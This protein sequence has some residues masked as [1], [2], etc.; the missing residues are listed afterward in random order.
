MKAF[1]PYIH[2]VT[3][4]ITRILKRKE[5]MTSFKPMTTIKQ[6]MRS[7]KDPIDHRQGKG[8]YKVSCSCGKCYI[9]ETG[10]SFKIRIKEHEPDIRNERMHTSA[11]A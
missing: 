1:L 9:G 5:I 6:R 11:L 7:V 10:R 3:N 4:K 2:G 8:I